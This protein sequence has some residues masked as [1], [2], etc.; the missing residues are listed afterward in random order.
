M[1][2]IKCSPA[3]WGIKKLDAFALSLVSG[4]KENAQK[5]FYIITVQL[6]LFTSNNGLSFEN[7]PN[8]LLGT[9]RR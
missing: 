7:L 2:G 3:Y 1:I 9:M 4:K 5:Y 6:L 8:F